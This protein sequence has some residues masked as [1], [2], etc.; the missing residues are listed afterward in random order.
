MNDESDE[1]EIKEILDE[2]FEKPSMPK[3]RSRLY[4]LVILAVIII[5]IIGLIGH[6]VLVYLAASSLK[7]AGKNFEELKTVTPL[8]TYKITF[9][10]T[11]ENP[12]STAI[13][14]EEINYRAYLEDEF[15]ASGKKSDF[16]IEPGTEKYFF[17]FRFD[18][19]DLPS[20]L[21]QLFIQKSA[22]LKISGTVTVPARF[23]GVLKYTEITLLYNITEEISAK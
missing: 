21:S 20:A 16:S 4:K 2:E 10:L 12:T 8:K 18:V 5:I 15:L 17:T 6:L 22:T 19:R 3:K 13:E 9:S 14:I 7:V 11:L 23:F 1:E